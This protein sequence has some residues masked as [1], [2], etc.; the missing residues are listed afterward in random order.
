MAY[1][2]QYNTHSES[3]GCENGRGRS[4]PRS[5]KRLHVFY[6]RTPSSQFTH[7]LLIA[8]VG[9]CI[10]TPANADDCNWRRFTQLASVVCRSTASKVGSGD[11]VPS[12]FIRTR[13]KH[14]SCA[15]PR[16]QNLTDPKEAVNLAANIS[17]PL[18]THD[19]PTDQ[20]FLLKS[21]SAVRTVLREF[22]A[23]RMARRGISIILPEPQYL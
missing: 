17:L 15:R 10:V 1:L 9:R 22:P 18:H 19:R 2:V 3:T 8:P 14:R 5:H 16:D 6:W 20:L 11:A 13:T 4:G 7:P 21:Q 23:R 12:H